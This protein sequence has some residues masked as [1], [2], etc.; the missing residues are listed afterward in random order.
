MTARPFRRDLVGENDQRAVALMLKVFGG[1]QDRAR[2]VWAFAHGMVSLE[3]AGRFPGAD[4]SAAWDVGLAALRS[5]DRT[6]HEGH[7][8]G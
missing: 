5:P 3:L 2:A 1:D 7:P 4:L 6:G 8:A